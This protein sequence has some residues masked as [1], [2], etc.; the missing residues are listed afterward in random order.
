MI[1]DEEIELNIDDFKTQYADPLTGVVDRSK[2]CFAA[3]LRTAEEPLTPNTERIYV[4]YARDKSVG[5]KVMRESVC[6]FAALR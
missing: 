5:I 2:I 1:S 6:A 4:F 3:E